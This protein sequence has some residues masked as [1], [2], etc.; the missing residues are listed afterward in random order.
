MRW[1]G[2]LL[3]LGCGDATPTVEA[4]PPERVS[5]QP[6]VDPVPAHPAVSPEEV[7]VV[8]E[9]IAALHALEATHSLDQVL[10]TVPYEASTPQRPSTQWLYAHHS[11]YHA[12]ANHIQGRVHAISADIQ[13]DLVVE[14]KDALKY[15]AGNVGRRFDTRWLESKHA[16]FQLIGVVNRLDKK[17]FYGHCGE[18]R[19]VYRLAYQTESKASSRLPVTMNV[20]MVPKEQD[21]V[22]VARQW[23]GNTPNLDLN[24]WAFKQLELNAQIVRFPSGLETEFAGQALYL[25]RVYGLA[26]EEGAVRAVEV[27][28]ENTPNVQALAKNASL[29]QDLV[30]WVNTHTADIDHGVY[31]IPERFLAN[32]AISYST[33]GI[34]RRANKPFDVVFDEALRAQLH[35][36]EGSFQ[37]VRSK[38][39]IIERLNN[40]SCVGCHQASTTAGFHFLGADDPNISG[41]TNRLALPFSAH[42]QREFTRRQHQLAQFM[43]GQEESTFRPHSLSPGTPTVGTNQSCILESH[44]HHLQPDAVWGC[45]SDETC[46]SV[47]SSDVGLPFGQCMPKKEAL[48]SGQTCRTGRIEDT[49][50]TDGTVFNL[51][52]YADTFSHK[53]RYDLSEEKRFFTDEYNCRPTR[54]GV[55]LGRTY[56]KCTG[57]ERRFVPQQTEPTH[58][59]VC[60][61]VGG[62]KF[63]SCVETDFHQCLDSIVGRGMVDSCHAGR[64]CRED[65]ICQAL[66]YALKGV[67]TDRGKALFD[68]G[69][70][71]CTPTYFVFQLRLD[72]HPVP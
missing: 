63:D 34:H 43:N 72:G 22:A 23:A 37:W 39:S 55:P 7:T 16:F 33:L 65:Y 67:D 12:I 27:P 32:E 45:G 40:G 53:Q 49:Q 20:V 70:G 17:D 52:A 46:E 2:L 62:A 58:P 10:P 42:V 21:C 41:V 44:R 64:F 47:V 36:P 24:Q 31:L 69:V 18:V 30:H 15:P 6:V 14:L 28:L 26:E 13:R 38:E 57:E 71:F 11:G 19:F 54:I 48:L 8:I 5:V 61:V 4:P 51:H 25:L 29:R 59:E 35:V 66:P 50:R 68:A 56:R 3:A 60:A 1:L 9:D